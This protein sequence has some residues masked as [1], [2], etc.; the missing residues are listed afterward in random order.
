M[1][2]STETRLMQ[3]THQKLSMYELRKVDSELRRYH[4]IMAQAFEPPILKV[5]LE[6][7]VDAV[8]YASD[9]KATYRNTEFGLHLTKYSEA[10]L[11]QAERLYETA[12]SWTEQEMQRIE[13]LEQS[14]RRQLKV[15]RVTPS[16][17]KRRRLEKVLEMEKSWQYN[18]AL[19]MELER[20]KDVIQNS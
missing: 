10:N 17:S 4:S 20:A 3:D 9:V 12:L 19:Y 13:K 2:I 6:R 15:M 14:Y 18:R 16:L 7:I 8:R 5:N 11:D 1:N